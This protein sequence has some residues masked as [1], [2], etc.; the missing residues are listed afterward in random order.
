VKLIA[1]TDFCSFEKSVQLP[2]YTLSVPNVFTPEGSPGYNDAFQIGFG[3]DLLTPA[4]TGLPVQLIVVDRWGK[5]VFETH[6]YRN[7]WNGAGLVSGVYYFQLR[8]GDLASCKNW[9]HIVK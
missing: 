9:V 7:D 8:V 6:D 4:E 2:V 5:R 1:E 3:P